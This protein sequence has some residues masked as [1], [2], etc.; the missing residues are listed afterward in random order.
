M[1]C[2]YSVGM[3]MSCKRFLLVG[4]CF[5]WLL[6][7]SVLWAQRIEQTINAGWRFSKENPHNAEAAVLDDSRWER[8][9]IP[10]SW[11]ADAYS[12][13]DYYRGIAWYRKTLFVPEEASRRQ[14][15]LR[16]EG[17]NVSAEVYVNGRF[18]Q[19]HRGGYTAFHVD[20]TSFVEYGKENLLAVKV[21]NSVQDLPPL[22]GDFSMFGGIYR[23]VWLIT[24]PKQHLEM[25]NAGSKG[26]FV[27]TPRVTDEEAEVLI[28]AEVRN[29]GSEAARLK[30][31][32]TLLDPEGRVVSVS[33]QELDVPAG[34][35]KSFRQESGP[36]HKPRLWSP[37][38]PIIYKVHTVVSEALSGRLLDEVYSP[39]GFRWFEFV[40][41]EGFFLNGKALKLIGV[42]RHQDQ[43]PLANALT[44]E[45]H[46]RDMLLAKEMGANFV[47]ISHYPQDDAVLEMCDRL[48][49]L[50]WEEIP[51]VN[52]VNLTKDFQ[53]VSEENL[54]EM[55]RQHY[56]HPS[57]VL[58]GYMNE[59]ALVTVRSIPEASKAEVYQRTKE[60]AEHLEA[61]LKKEDPG[62][63]SAIAYHNNQIYHTIGISPIVD[64]IGWNLYHGWYENNLDAFERFVKREN[65]KYPQ[66]PLI[67]SEYGAGSDK[68]LHS[69]DP[70][71]F[72][73]SIEHQQA[74]H[75]YYLPVIA[76]E[77]SI[78]GSTV[79]NFVDFGSGGRDESMPRIN[80]KGLL[81]ADRTPKDVYFYYKAFLRKDVP[82]VH[83][84]SR[85]WA[86]RSGVQKGNRPVELPVKVYANCPE[87]ELFVNGRSLGKKKTDN[88]LAV[89]TVS[90]S[91]GQSYLRA[92]GRFEGKTV[93]DGMPIS[94]L[95]L[96]DRLVE[97]DGKYWEL[98]VNV[99][100][101]CSFRSEES[102]M[103]WLPD[104][105][106][107][108]GGWG[109]IGGET[110][111][112]VK[113]RIGSQVEIQGTSDGP[114][115]QTLRKDVEAYRWDVPAGRYEVELLFAD[116]FS[117]AGKVVYNL[118]D[119]D[120]S[121]AVR[122]VFDVVINKKT[123][124]K[125]LDV[126]REFGVFHAVKKRFIVDVG[127]E[128]H[129]L[130]EFSV[131]QGSSF[132]NGVKLR[133][134]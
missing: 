105:P 90:F 67:I 29:D 83:I 53:Q 65:E 1:C 57:V 106:Y 18:V 117:P 62:R 113:N 68:R 61:I 92:V 7:G 63:C 58:W 89:W 107:E 45:M 23:D 22:S 9:N 128:G 64:V 21:D 109:Y 133:R 69:L 56:N 88:C 30:L 132:L 110:F 49:L 47:R 134:L 11:N 32:N 50:V 31:V 82:V 99:G 119:E 75:E 91:D 85:D 38:T 114:L 26:V 111:Y 19:K 39:L 55:I 66:Y 40:G 98:A 27:S 16:F 74:Y 41:S 80:N 78:V 15:F 37:D 126:R 52:T 100:S 125:A 93:E 3:I 48:G 103:N 43:K 71:P 60:L 10:H 86:F 73:F 20:I 54:V 101:N 81:Y 46:R 8:V 120:E 84:A 87:V 13:K 36:V 112:A 130:L 42:C 24:T 12:R 79:W 121:Q 97:A 6:A 95:A 76:R 34:A 77:K 122:P 72:D 108:P 2:F 14:S 35:T 33:E 17:V 70:Q 96:P 104:R 28:R 115:Y 124:A 127:Q 51:I 102:G 116:V 59:S 5:L 94:F 129:V 44:D 123:L 4:F 131:R 118:V 25:L